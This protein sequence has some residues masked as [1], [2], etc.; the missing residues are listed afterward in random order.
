MLPRAGAASH[1]GG[2]GLDSGLGY[3][4]P[5]AAE[6]TED[7]ALRPA[8]PAGLTISDGTSMSVAIN[9]FRGHV[10]LMNFWATWCAPCIKEMAYL[11]RL[12]GDLKGMPL[13]VMPVSEDKGGIAVAKAFMQRQK[14]T[15]LRTYADPNGA[16]AE[17]LNVQGLPTSFIIDKQG[18]LVQR[19][20]GPYEWDNGANVAKFRAL[21]AEAP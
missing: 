4:V 6:S 10:L 21:V 16:T 15:F 14:L 11:D 12:Q 9:R 18:R 1:D 3:I 20:E 17:T 7:P 5:A 8:M 13:L 19:V 2:Q